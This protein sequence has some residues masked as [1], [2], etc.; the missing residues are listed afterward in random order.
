MPW[1]SLSATLMEHIIC[2][3]FKDSQ[4]QNFLLIYADFLGRHFVGGQILLLFH[5]CDE[6]VAILTFR[7]CN[8]QI[9]SEG[10]C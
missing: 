5:V 4:I 2:I 7:I 6:A 9:C 10:S 1:K 3:L 8:E